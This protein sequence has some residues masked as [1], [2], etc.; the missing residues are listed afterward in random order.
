M[1]AEIKALLE[2]LVKATE[3]SVYWGRLNVESNLRSAAK[4]D[5][6][7]DMTGLHHLRKWDDVSQRFVIL[8]DEEIVEDTKLAMR[9]RDLQYDV[10]LDR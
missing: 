9:I 2:R 3:E 7:Y 8:S 10:K 6:F 1:D 4:L 5:A